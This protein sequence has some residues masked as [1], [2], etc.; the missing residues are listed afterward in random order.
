MKTVLVEWTFGS[1]TQPPVIIHA[2]RRFTVRYRHISRTIIE[3][4]PEIYMADGSQFSGLHKLNGRLPV[5]PG[6]LLLSDLYKALVFPGSIHHH[7]DL[8]DGVGQRL[9][10]IY[11]LPGSTCFHSWEAMPVIRS[12]YDHRINVFILQYLAVVLL[13]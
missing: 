12:S 11:M 9:F 5:I 10:H 3:I 7:I 13:Q 6:A 2:F 4:G 1:R 8:P